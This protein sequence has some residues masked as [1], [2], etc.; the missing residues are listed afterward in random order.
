MKRL[1]TLDT[2]S[3]ILKAAEATKKK[4]LDREPNHWNIT[5]W[6][7][8]GTV[9]NQFIIIVKTQMLFNPFP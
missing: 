4:V 3:E 6:A 5:G 2:S 1:D 7:L 9:R 8:F